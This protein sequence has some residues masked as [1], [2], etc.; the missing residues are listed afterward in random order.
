MT[1]KREI[2]KEIV[3]EGKWLRFFNSHFMDTESEPPK[4]RTYEC[5]ERIGTR[6][7]KA[8]GVEM[9]VFVHHHKQQ[10]QEDQK[11]TEIVIVEQYRA[12]VNR[13]CVEFPAGLVEKG[14]EVI[15]GALRELK[16]ETGLSA[17]RKSVRNGTNPLVMIDPSITSDSEQIFVI[18]VD[19]DD[20]RNFE[21]Q[22]KQELDDDEHIVV[23][24][25]PLKLFRVVCEEYHRRGFFNDAKVW[26]FALTISSFILN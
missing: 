5:I 4:M 22:K 7:D 15:E 26:V 24:M 9:I 13:K 21:P 2:K 3:Q 17:E 14:E 19:G 25:I 16:E 1:G 20:P 12:P 6:E 10:Q 8:D 23:R 11:E 18:D